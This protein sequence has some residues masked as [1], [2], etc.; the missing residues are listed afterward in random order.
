VGS[1]LPAD[2]FVHADR[3]ADG[4]SSRLR[5]ERWK[6]ADGTLV[7]IDLM[8]TKRGTPC[9]L[10][11]TGSGE[12]RCLPASAYVI[13]FTDQSCTVPIAAASPNNCQPDF[14]VTGALLSEE[15]AGCPSPLHVYNVGGQVSPPPRA[16]LETATGC[17]PFNPAGLDFYTATE[18]P[19]S[20]F[21]KATIVRPK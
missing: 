7:P 12:V 3:Q 15:G 9:S 21:A 16:F 19:L 8:D 10:Y 6:M 14:P 20:D 5:V 17:V 11:V 2:A 4:G 1:P 18:A 13:L